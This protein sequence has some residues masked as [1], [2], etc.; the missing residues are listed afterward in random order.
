MR[1][2]LHK[3]VGKIITHVLCKV[4]FFFENR[5][6]NEIMWRN[7]VEPGGPQLTIWQMRIACWIP[8]ATNA[9]SVY[10][11][12]IAFPLQQWLHERVSVWRH[13]YI[14][15]LSSVSPGGT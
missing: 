3:A 9:H 4:I 15:Y 2:F 13:T 7:I 11:M 12:V 6:V 5:A 14:A 1:N 10:V 8:K